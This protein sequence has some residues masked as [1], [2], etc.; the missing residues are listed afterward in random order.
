[1]PAIRRRPSPRTIVLERLMARPPAEW[2]ASADALLDSL[3]VGAETA[4]GNCA[5]VINFFARADPVAGSWPYVFWCG[6][7][8]PQTTAIEGKDLHLYQVEARGLESTARTR[9]P[10]AS[11]CCSVVAAPEDRSR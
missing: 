2:K 7:K 10:A 11:R 9:R 6:T 8:A 3:E 1:M 5:L 4:A